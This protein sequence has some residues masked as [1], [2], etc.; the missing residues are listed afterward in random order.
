M[1]CTETAGGGGDKPS[2]AFSLVLITWARHSIKFRHDGSQSPTPGKVGDIQTCLVQRIRLSPH[3]GGG[4][5]RSEVNSGSE[6]QQL[7]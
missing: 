3:A 1:G 4:V 2:H 7:P 6:V 5:R